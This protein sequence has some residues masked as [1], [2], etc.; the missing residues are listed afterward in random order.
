MV[1]SLVICDRSLV[2]PCPLWPWH[3]WKAL[4][5]YFMECPSIWLCLMFSHH[6]IEVTHYGKEYHRGGAPFPVHYNKEL[7]TLVC[8]S[9]DVNLDYL[10]KTVSAGVLLCKCT[11]FPLW[12]VNIVEMLW[13][14]ANIPVSAWTL[15]DSCQHSLVV[16]ICGNYY[17][18]ILRVIF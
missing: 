18:G 3:F 1:T 12:L 8:S 16:L 7:T 14:Y 2:F 4:I 13:G 10:V 17:C 6:L 9:N 5:S 15:A 11:H